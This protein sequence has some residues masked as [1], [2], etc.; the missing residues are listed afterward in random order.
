MRIRGARGLNGACVPAHS[1]SARHIEGGDHG[2]GLRRRGQLGRVSVGARAVAAEHRQRE[3]V[4]E[5]QEVTESDRE[6]ATH[7]CARWDPQ[8]GWQGQRRTAR[9]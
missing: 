8:A 6:G 3:Q 1:P 9:R 2:R 4:R 7:A 5:S